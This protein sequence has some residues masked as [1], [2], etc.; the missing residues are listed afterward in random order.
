MNPYPTVLYLPSIP[1]LI[2][3]FTYDLPQQFNK[4]AFSLRGVGGRTV[5]LG[6]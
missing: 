2:L 3:S 1:F 5:A 6:L 4:F